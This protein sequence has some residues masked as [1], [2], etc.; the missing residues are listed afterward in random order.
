VIIVSGRGEPVERVV[1]LEL[2]ADDYRR[3]ALRLP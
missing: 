2:G 3:Q 1:G